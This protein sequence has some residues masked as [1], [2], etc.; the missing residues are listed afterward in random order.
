M[1]SRSYMSLSILEAD[2][3]FMCRL[4]SDE[5]GEGGHFEFVLIEVLFALSLEERDDYL[6]K[7]ES[8][9]DSS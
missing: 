2:A 3:G 5:A 6:V 7:L 8:S 9:V 1:K 4:I